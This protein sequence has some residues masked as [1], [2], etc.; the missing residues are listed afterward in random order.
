M[1]SALSYDQSDVRIRV[2]ERRESDRCVDVY[3]AAWRGM[4]FAPQDLHTQEEDRL[5]MQ[6]VFARQLVLVA[7]A[8]GERDGAGKIVGLLSMSD[9]TVHNLYIQPGYQNRGIGHRLIET[10]K[11]CSGGE[12]KLWVFEPNEGA[13]RF[14]ERHG[15]STVRKTDGSDNKE[16]VPDRLMAWRVEAP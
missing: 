6:D 5:W 2:A 8:G 14:Y 4:R 7:E 13:I 15:F 11:T 10:A 16:K 3:R 1:R 9:G 12:L